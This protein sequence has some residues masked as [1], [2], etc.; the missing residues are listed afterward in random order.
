MTLEVLAN[1]GY[2]AS[3]MTAPLVLSFALPGFASER[4][5]VVANLSPFLCKIHGRVVAQATPPALGHCYRRRKKTPLAASN[6]AS[7]SRVMA[8]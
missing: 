6:C 4:E 5:R 7:W 3:G 2:T 8:A 1:I